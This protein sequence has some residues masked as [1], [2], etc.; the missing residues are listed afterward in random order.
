MV[1]YVPLRKILPIK[2]KDYILIIFEVGIM[3][4]KLTFVSDINIVL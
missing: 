4:L 1:N 3:D 2:F